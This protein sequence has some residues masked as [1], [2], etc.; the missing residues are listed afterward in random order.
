M[1]VAQHTS[2]RREK[3][4]QAPEAPSL[5]SHVEPSTSGACV[6]PCATSSSSSRRRHDSPSDT[7]LPQS[8]HKRQVSH[9]QELEVVDS[10][11]PP[12]TLDASESV[13]PSIIDPIDP[14]PPPE[15]EAVADAKLE[16]FGR[17]PVDLSLL[18]LYPDHTSR[19]I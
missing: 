14:V 2:M 4:Q 3:S 17:A 7:S 18:S 19:H 9:I 10:P 16:A 15:G 6:S 11:M 1:R 5:S 8:S 12:P 13:P